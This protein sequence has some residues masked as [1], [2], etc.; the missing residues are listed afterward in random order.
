VISKEAAGRADN[1]VIPIESIEHCYTGEI[2]LKCYMFLRNK[3]I[4]KRITIIYGIISGIY[5]EKLVTAKPITAASARTPIGTAAPPTP[6]PSPE[7]TADD[8]FSGGGTPVKLL[9]L[10]AASKTSNI[11]SRLRS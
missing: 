7:L 3:S 6:E 8:D 10:S 11:W 5:W 4:P 2:V 9:P 1:C